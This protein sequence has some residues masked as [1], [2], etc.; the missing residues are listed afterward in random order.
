MQQSS[1]LRGFAVLVLVIYSLYALSTIGMTGLLFYAIV[2][3]FT[4]MYLERFE[5][6]A[7]SAV[8]A[9]IVV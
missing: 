2:G 5:G 1:A 6:A 9:G 8:L 4:Y 7:M 3:L